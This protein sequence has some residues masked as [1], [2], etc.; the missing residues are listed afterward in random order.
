MTA[1]NVT[2]SVEPTQSGALSCLSV[3]PDWPGAPSW[4]HIAVVVTFMNKESSSV[5]VSSLTLSF[6]G[7]SVPS[8]VFQ[9]GPGLE[10]AP[11][12]PVVWAAGRVVSGQADG[13]P[14][15]V[16][17]QQPIPS[18][19]MFAAVCDGFD[20]PTSLAMPLALHV[21]PTPQ[22]S[23]RFWGIPGDL[24]PGEYWVGQAAV[25]AVSEAG[26]Q[27]YAYDVGVEQTTA[28]ARTTAGTCC[29]GHGRKQERALPDLGEVASRSCRRKGRRL[30]QRLP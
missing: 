11:G 17:V 12:S 21:S 6:P 24:K 13:S 2:L 1:A 23:F 20:A 10:L 26:S 7:A 25:H 5:H 8:H 16:L 14:D 22:G 4:A 28:A 9:L 30:S 15:P 27:L 18:S 29:S 19:V 3:A